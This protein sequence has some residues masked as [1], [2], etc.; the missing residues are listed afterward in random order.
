MVR[1]LL[2]NALHASKSAV[3]VSA[4]SENTE[5]LVEVV[6]QGSGIPE[7]LLNTIRSGQTLTSKVNGNGI[8]LASAFSWAKARGYDL[9][10]D[11]SV[12]HDDHGTRIQI[13]I[14]RTAWSASS[15]RAESLEA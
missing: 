9:A 5:Y 3:T 10:I 4:R 15:D 7:S 8:G 12:K 1:N 13:R 2:E 6:D 11:S 14:P